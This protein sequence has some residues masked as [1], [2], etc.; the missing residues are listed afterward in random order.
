MRSEEV[1]RG[2]TM[3]APCRIDPLSDI[4]KTQRQERRRPMG[5]LEGAPPCE[6]NR[7]GSAKE[8][9]CRVEIGLKE[10]WLARVGA[11]D[12]GTGD[13]NGMRSS[14]TKDLDV[15]FNGQTGPMPATARS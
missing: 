13:W 1:S 2:L 5:L 12:H 14:G 7:P 8:L 4:A 11:R 10:D 6:E 9:I 15:E 3:L